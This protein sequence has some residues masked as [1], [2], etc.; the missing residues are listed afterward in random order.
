MAEINLSTLLES[1][2]VIPFDQRE[3][4]AV[5][6]KILY[7]NGI[8]DV[9]Y[10]GSNISQLTSVISYVIGTLNVNTA[11]N[12]QETILPL[13][14][15][16]MNAMFGA[17]QL[18]YEPH[19]KKAFRYNLSI[20]P[21]YDDTKLNN[22]GSIN[23]TDQTPRSIDL[24]QNTAF[25]SGDK[26]Y[27]YRGET[28]TSVFN[29][30]NFEIQHKSD[31]IDPQYDPDVS[32]NDFFYEIEVVEGTMTKWED[33]PTLQFIARDFTNDAGIQEVNQDFLIPYHNVE[34]NGLQVYIKS[35]DHS[36]APINGVLPYEQVERTKSDHFLIDET[37]TY[38]QNKFIR[39]ENI[40]LQYP[41]IFFEYSGMGQPVKSGDNI[42]VNVFQTL[43][44][45]GGSEDPFIVQDTVASQLF[46][47]KSSELSSV[48][49]S[50]ES[51]D[52]IKKN[53]TVFN[54]TANRAVTKLDYLAISRRHPNV[55][56]SEAWGGED[57]TPPQLGHI[58]IS[59]VPNYTKNYLYTAKDGSE[60]EKHENIVGTTISG[61]S[62][63]LNNW[64]QTDTSV[65]DIIE[66]LDFYK[67]M[68]M[69]IHHRHPLYVNFDFIVDI[70]KYDMTKSKTL[71]NELIWKGMDNYFTDQIEQFNTEYLNSN[72]QRVLDT[73]LSY[74][75][76]IGY[77]IKVTGSLFR[78]M[79]DV[80]SGG[81]IYCSL[82]FPFEDMFI[83]TDS[84]LRP[85]LLPNIDTLSFG[86]S[87]E[88]LTVDYSALAP[89][90]ISQDSLGTPILLG[91]TTV[92]TYTV[93]RVNSTIDLVFDIEGAS[94]ETSVFGNPT[95]KYSSI[96]NFPV[97]GVADVLYIAP[98]DDN[99]DIEYIW[100]GAAYTTTGADALTNEDYAEFNIQYPYSSGYNQNVPFAKNTMPRL[101]QAEFKDN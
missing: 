54:N 28:I 10:E 98:D 97:T 64:Y 33:D 82:D 49:T 40:I 47:V 21:Q 63:N 84:H 31:Y 69:Q 85:S 76:G 88:D 46:K 19:P 22:D 17:R 90:T 26:T 77:E 59:T 1:G 15:K 79:K 74:Q 32:Y 43:G 37:F 53:A 92:G 20:T 95:Y 14:T 83:D 52:S 66:Y 9:L 101:R 36:V 99:I 13:A 62:T 29:F 87:G 55:F 34:E 30:S 96:D 4:D 86:F 16:R 61:D 72:L 18:G 75:S 7:E 35:I 2:S 42:L 24:I 81:A 70:V 57:E 45:D 51:M 65:N 12:L 25:Q 5:M 93:N 71:I 23:T 50:E 78:N 94:L 80:F 3:I 8:S 100:S 91:V 48:G 67:V 89:L 60:L 27:Y 38:D 56:D 41:V 44:A 68:T 39:Q 11:I 73:I 58:W 6:R